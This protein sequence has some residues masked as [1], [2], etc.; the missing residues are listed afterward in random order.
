MNILKKIKQ[1]GYTLEQVAKEMSN[2]RG[3]GKGVSQPTLS[4]IINGNPTIDRLQEIAGIIGVSLSE[5][6]ADDN[7]FDNYITCPH[8]G[9][10]IPIDIH[11]RID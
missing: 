7:I 10:K 6:V 5:L 11:I 1:K 4:A 9:E 8:C 2:T 3:G